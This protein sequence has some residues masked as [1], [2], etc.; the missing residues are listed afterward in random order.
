M[1]QQFST[2]EIGNRFRA[3]SNTEL[4]YRSLLPMSVQLILVM[5][6][7]A[8]QHSGQFSDL[9]RYCWQHHIA[10]YAMDLRGF[11]QSTG[12]RGHVYS[13]E[14]Y[15]DDLE[16]FL[17]LIRKLHPQIPIFLLGHS[18][19]GTIAI[20]YGQERKTLIRGAVL[21][22]PA[23]RI[24]LQ[25]PKYIHHASHVLSRITPR[26]SV[27]L[28][29]WHHVLARLSLLSSASLE[30]MDPLSTNQYSA[31]WLTELLS[32][33]SRSFSKVNDF[34]ISALCL[35]GENDSLIDPAA[36]QEFHDFLQVQDKKCII[37]PD[38]N[39]RLLQDKKKVVVYQ[40]IV[41]WLL[42]H[43]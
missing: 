35:C 38:S 10:F 27:D 17:R 14:E 34:Q 8:G 15:L 33:G 29:K 41:N 11:G 1:P 9:G 6:H 5:I 3:N 7:G 13:F 22:A 43:I 12:Q 19:G 26:L 24:N 25:I 30:E 28:N 32:N 36:V 42:E 40:H 39:H 37:F 16:A 23:L 4:F 2:W 18:L 20:R 31:R 21:S